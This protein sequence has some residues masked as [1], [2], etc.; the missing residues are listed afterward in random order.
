MLELLVQL[1]QYIYAS[2]FI[3]N[4]KLS[5]AMLHVII[6]INNNNNNNNNLDL[7]SA[8]QETQGRFT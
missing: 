6:I 7:Y 5:H 2:L 1:C 8:F 4:V 3:E